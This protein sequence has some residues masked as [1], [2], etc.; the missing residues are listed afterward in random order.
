M[1]DTSEPQAPGDHDSAYDTYSM[2]G[3]LDS[4]SVNE[5]YSQYSDIESGILF[6]DMQF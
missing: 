1:A 3:D 2:P 5:P 4:H 6:D